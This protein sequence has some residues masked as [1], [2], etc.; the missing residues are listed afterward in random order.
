M[1]GTKLNWVVPL[2]FTFL[3]AI[4]TTPILLTTSS[5]NDTSNNSGSTTVSCP[6]EVIGYCINDG[7]CFYLIDLQAVACTFPDLYEGKRCGKK[8][9]VY[10]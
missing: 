2:T 5:Q 9:M 10:L 8:S 1:N 7:Y 3:V 4:L 6:E